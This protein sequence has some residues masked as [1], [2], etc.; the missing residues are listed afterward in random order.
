MICIIMLTEREYKL[1]GLEIL[2]KVHQINETRVEGKYEK[3]F[4]K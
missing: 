3:M 1:V 2:G 4:G